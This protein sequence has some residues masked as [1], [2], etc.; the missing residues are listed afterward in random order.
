[1]KRLRRQKWTSHP[2]TKGP[3]TAASS[4]PV[5]GKASRTITTIK[6]MRDHKDTRRKIVRGIRFRRP[7][8]AAK[9]A[10]STVRRQRLNFADENKLDAVPLPDKPLRRAQA[11]AT[12]APYR[13]RD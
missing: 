8:R 10:A 3:P 9:T 13:G 1:M 5:A 2:A 7:E 4:G 12:M 6:A 11:S